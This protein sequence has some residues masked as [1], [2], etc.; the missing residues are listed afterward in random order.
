MM[1]P[2]EY[3]HLLNYIREHPGATTREIT[4]S[5]DGPQC[6]MNENRGRIYLKCSKL[7]KYEKVRCEKD[8]KNIRWWVR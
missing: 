4:E 1:I 7:L 5:L 6:N 3:E 2:V 8:G